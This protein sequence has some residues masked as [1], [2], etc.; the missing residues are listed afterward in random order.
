MPPHKT[1]KTKSKKFWVYK[2]KGD[3]KARKNRSSIDKKNLNSMK[4]NINNR[5]C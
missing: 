5:K 4:F 3:S 2:K 1:R